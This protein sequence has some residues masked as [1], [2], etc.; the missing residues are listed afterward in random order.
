MGLGIVIVFFGIKVCWFFIEII[1]C[2]ENY[3]I[4][5]I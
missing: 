5:V 1:V 2:K 3:E 4:K